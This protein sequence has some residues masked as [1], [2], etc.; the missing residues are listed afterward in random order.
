MKLRILQSV[1]L[2]LL[3]TFFVAKA[4]AENDH[5][6]EIGPEISSHSLKEKAYGS[7]ATKLTG[8]MIGVQGSW[9][10]HLGRNFLVV[11]PRYAASKQ[12]YKNI[13]SNLESRGHNS[14]FEARGLFGRDFDL[15]ADAVISPYLGLGY[16]SLR[17]QAGKNLG[18]QNWGHLSG[19]DYLYVPV[20]FDTQVRIQD[21]WRFIANAEL[22]LILNAGIRAT[23]FGSKNQ[24]H[25]SKGFG[26]RSSMGVGVDFASLTLEAK[27]FYR[28]WS[29]DASGHKCSFCGKHSHPKNSSSEFGFGVSLKF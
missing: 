7:N 14:L 22:D 6:F 25:T 8:T 12:K 1:A 11:N 3:T 4:E 13:T 26:L 21:M 17:N 9:V 29:V 5:Q 2:S 20:G 19:T 16:R 23:R 10:L 24:T 18:N 15:M 27:P 28:Y